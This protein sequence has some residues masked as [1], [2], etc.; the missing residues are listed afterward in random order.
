M[1]SDS[2]PESE[3]QELAARAEWTPPPSPIFC[4]HDDFAYD[5]FARSPEQPA[6]GAEGGHAAG[7][8]EAGSRSV[9]RLPTLSLGAEQ[10]YGCGWAPAS[11]PSAAQGGRSTAGTGV[12]TDGGDA[13]RTP[14]DS[15][16]RC[17]A[18]VPPDTATELAPSGNSPAQLRVSA[19]LSPD[20]SPCAHQAL[21]RAPPPLASQPPAR[22]PLGGLDDNEGAGDEQDFLDDDVVFLDGERCPA[23]VFQSRSCLL[24]TSPSPRD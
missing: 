1:I 9:A 10:D 11:S 2:E 23:H 19:L 12:A 15:P 13:S 4:A 20:R 8:R 5:D 6:A 21:P 18:D 14:R 3:A 7:G 17:G 22:V 24:Y 16:R